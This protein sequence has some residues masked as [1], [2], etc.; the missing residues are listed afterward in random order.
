M[1]SRRILL[2][3]RVLL[4]VLAVMATIE[5]APHRRSPRPR[6]HLEAILSGLLG[7][8]YGYGNPYEAAAAYG[9]EGY[10]AEYAGYGQGEEGYYG[11]GGGY[12]GGNAPIT[13]EIEAK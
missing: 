4:A 6:R 8:Q 2:V 7:T 5:A 12:G 3:L 11:Y 9:Y 13:I 1:S 10:G